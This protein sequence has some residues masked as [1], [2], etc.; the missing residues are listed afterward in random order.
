MISDLDDLIDRALKED[1]TDADVTTNPL[2]STPHIGRARLIA[3]DDLILSGS[4]VFTKVVQRLEPQAE[5]KW[6][7]KNGDLVLKGQNMATLYCNTIQLLKAERVA[8]NFLGRMCG[9]ATLTQCFV[10]QIEGLPCKIIDTRKTTPLLRHLEKKA[11]LDGGGFNHRMSLADAVLIK[12]NHIAL[13]GG[14][15]PAVEAIRKQHPEFIEVE[16]KNMREVREAIQLQVN[17]IMLDNMSN[18][19]M[20]EAVQEIPSSIEIEA[21]GNMSLDRVRAVAELG[22]HFIS[23]GAITHSA[24]CADISLEFSDLEKAKK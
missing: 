17:R 12:D 3:K 19:M 7:F 1:R 22:V 9:I 5:I 15:K 8:L 6:I 21:S 16:T 23:V 10:K 24:P 2:S 20:K 18:E 13:M 4:E 11:V 14:I